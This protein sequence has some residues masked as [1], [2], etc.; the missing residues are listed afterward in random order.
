MGLKDIEHVRIEGVAYGP[1]AVAGAVERA[2]ADI[3]RV[4]AAV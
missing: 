2:S 3:E 1:E 4:A